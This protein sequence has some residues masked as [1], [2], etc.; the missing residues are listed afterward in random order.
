M[1]S[2]EPV[3]D[4]F[5]PNIAPKKLKSKKTLQIREGELTM[6]PLR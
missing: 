2:V 6:V 3:G 5:W 1:T 4:S